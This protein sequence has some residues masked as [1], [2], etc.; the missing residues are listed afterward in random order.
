MGAGGSVGFDAETLAILEAE[1]AKPS[2]AAD[3]ADLTAARK[4]LS[5]MRQAAR[6][7]GS[8][9]KLPTREFSADVEMPMHAWFGTSAGSTST[10]SSTAAAS[11]DASSGTRVPQVTVS[12]VVTV[13]ATDFTIAT[14]PGAAERWSV[15]YSRPNAEDVWT[16]KQRAWIRVPATAETETAMKAI[17]L[18]LDDP[19]IATG[20]LAL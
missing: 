1:A 4:E 16:S 15:Q 9:D 20:L 19:V 14:A 2:D 3:I 12:V 7:H 17:A 18:I 10:S 8:R 6:S 11:S 5:R 13:T